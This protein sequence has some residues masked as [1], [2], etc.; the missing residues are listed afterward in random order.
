MSKERAEPTWDDLQVGD[1]VIELDGLRSVFVI[2]KEGSIAKQR[3]WDVVVLASNHPNFEQMPAYRANWLRRT[4]SFRGPGPI[5]IPP[6]HEVVR[7]G[8]TIIRT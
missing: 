1:T 7:S 6:N 4:G 2:A 5:P 8:V 3:H